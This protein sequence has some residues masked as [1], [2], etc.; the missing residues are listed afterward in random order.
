MLSNKAMFSYKF[1]VHIELYI[2]IKNFQTF[3]W[4]VARGSES[5][6]TGIQAF[7]KNHLNNFDQTCQE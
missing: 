2:I 5:M 3:S 6:A 7:L 4:K 1:G